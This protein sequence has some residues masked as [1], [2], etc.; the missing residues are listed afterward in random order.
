MPPPLPVGPHSCLPGFCPLLV[1][2]HLPSFPGPFPLTPGFYRGFIA[3]SFWLGMASM[4]PS[5]CLVIP[6]FLVR[7]VL[8]FA[9]V[10]LMCPQKV[11]ICTFCLRTWFHHIVL[12]SFLQCRVHWIGHSCGARSPFLILTIRSQISAGRLHTV[13]CTLHSVL[14]PLDCQFPLF[15]LQIFCG[16]FGA[17]VLFLSSSAECSLLTSVADVQFFFHVP[18]PPLL[19]CPL[20]LQL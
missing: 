13:F 12:K 5:P 7:P 6:L 3:L 4:V 18:C 9:A 2:C 14:S 10:C 19:S 1:F 15:L 16:V 20:R 17:S 11:G 8:M